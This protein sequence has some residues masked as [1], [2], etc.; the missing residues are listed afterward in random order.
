MGSSPVVRTV[1]DVIRMSTTPDR[2]VR[3]W[4]ALAKL[5]V[6][7]GTGPAASVTPHPKSM[8]LGWLAPHVAELLSD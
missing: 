1:H 6:D 3:W 8:P 7:G 5:Q 2:D 4:E